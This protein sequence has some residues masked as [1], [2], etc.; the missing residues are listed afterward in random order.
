MV[1]DLIARLRAR[2]ADLPAP[3]DET[4]LA[5]AEGSL[6]FALP[7][8]VRR[9]Y[10]EVADGGFGPGFG[11]LS[12]EEAVARYHELR[13]GELLPR[14]RSWPEGLLPLVHH[15]PAWEC[16]EAS[17]GRV[18]DWDPE[19]LEERSDE[20]QFSRSFSEVAPSVE[21]WL[22]EWVESRTPAERL[23]EQTAGL[24]VRA[25]RDA[26]EQVAAMTPE[27]R[28]RLNLPDEGWERV[29]LA[30]FGLDEHD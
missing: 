7:P 28:A 13:T 5:R 19:E 26:L 6:G 25:A 16:V 12:L 4:E 2:G 21:S 29:F 18:I 9:A 30:R 11:L 20:E 15:D 14:G 3:A 23:A 8:A 17:T 1:D 22:R 24:H 27:E 10:A